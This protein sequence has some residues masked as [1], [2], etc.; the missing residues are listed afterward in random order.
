MLAWRILVRGFRF[1]R[2]DNLSKEAE[3]FI[4]LSLYPYGDL[5]TDGE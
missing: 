3:L 2:E 5:S 1:K 4:N